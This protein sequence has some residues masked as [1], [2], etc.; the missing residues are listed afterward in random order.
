MLNILFALMLVIPMICEAKI[1]V[2]AGSTREGSYNKKLAC[3]A[4]RIAT[5]R[6][7]EVAIIDLKDYPMPLYDGDMEAAEGLP[8]NASK[9]QALMAASEGVV[10]ATPQYNASIPAV[11]KNAID[12]LTR[13]GS[14][15][16][17]FE[18]FAGKKFAIMSASPGKRGGARALVHLKDILLDCHAEL[19][20]KQVSLPAAHLAFD[21]EGR[22]KDVAIQQAL[23]EEIDQL[24]AK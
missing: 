23:A 21:S 1:L 8:V 12:W 15:G 14:G 6:G 13:D 7:A 17:S 16:S 2:F 4:A 5:A 11:L 19:V 20:T 10:I 18:S 3:E 24:L 22:L 9:L